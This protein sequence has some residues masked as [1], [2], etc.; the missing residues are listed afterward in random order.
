VRC[1]SLSAWPCRQ[2]SLHMFFVF[3]F[4]NESL[5][6]PVTVTRGSIFLQPNLSCVL[7]F[8]ARRVFAPLTGSPSLSLQQRQPTRLVVST[9]HLHEAIAFTVPCDAPECTSG[10]QQKKRPL[11][12][13]PTPFL[14]HVHL[15]KKK[16][17]LLSY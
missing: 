1:S 16:A 15:T 17:N 6:I 11:R 4:K 8:R 3:C 5:L 9:R 14:L 2:R 7:N 13:D 10:I 12:L